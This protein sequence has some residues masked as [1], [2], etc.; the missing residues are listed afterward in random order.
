M[1]SSIPVDL[2]FFHSVTPENGYTM[3]NGFIFE[4]N[5][6]STDAKGITSVKLQRRI[7]KTGITASE[8]QL[9]MKFAEI[10][11]ENM[12]QILDFANRYGLLAGTDSVNVDGLTTP[13]DK[14]RFWQEKIF[15][16]QQAVQI[17]QES[18]AQKENIRFQWRG[19]TLYFYMGTA[20][21]IRSYRNTGTRTEGEGFF[22]PTKKTLF[23]LDDHPEFK[24]IPKTSYRFW[25]KVVVQKIVNENLREFPAPPQLLFNRT[26]G[27]VSPLNEFSLRLYPARLLPVL[28]LQLIKYVTGETQLKQC[29]ACHEWHDAKKA[30]WKSLCN[31]C[32]TSRRQYK[33]KAKKL[34][35]QGASL[36]E[37]LRRDKK[38]D[39]ALIREWVS[40]FESMKG[41]SEN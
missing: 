27:K 10:D 13:A 8:P 32:T 37:I 15:E 29:T 4:G 33:F 7:K 41:E 28:F 6:T 18:Q 17:W 39:P 9:F 23:T 35:T 1:K 3:K 22:P 36:E 25:A 20:A 21:D 30:R 14:V 2:T 5:E 40:E 19:D 11:A 31:K 26:R 38:T 34:F 16:M 24:E 12:Q